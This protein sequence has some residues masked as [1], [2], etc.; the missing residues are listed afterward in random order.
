MLYSERRPLHSVNLET[1]VDLTHIFWC[2][3]PLKSLIRHKL[4]NFEKSWSLSRMDHVFVGS[5]ISHRYLDHRISSDV[6]VDSCNI[7]F[8]SEF[9]NVPSVRP[10]ASFREKAFGASMPGTQDAQYD[11]S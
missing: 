3:N 9:G 4:L 7:I 5:R 10:L 2:D 11:A 6:N 1:R 8:S